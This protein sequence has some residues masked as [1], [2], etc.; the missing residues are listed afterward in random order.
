M[1]KVLTEAALR[2]MPAGKLVKFSMEKDMEG[3]FHHAVLWAW[4]D[5]NQARMSLFDAFVGEYLGE[6]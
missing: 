1:E 4:M 3:L 2:K 5:G 6:G